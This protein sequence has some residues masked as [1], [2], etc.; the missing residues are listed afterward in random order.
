MRYRWT[1]QRGPLSAPLQHHGAQLPWAEAVFTL[2][3]AS[4]KLV[5][6]RLEALDCAS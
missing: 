2:R 1:W 4:A 6:D 5:V 3:V